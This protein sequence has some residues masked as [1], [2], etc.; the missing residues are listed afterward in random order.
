M[1]FK[2][3]QKQSKKYQLLKGK[4]QH[5]YLLKK[6]EVDVLTSHHVGK[7]GFEAIKVHAFGRLQVV[8]HTFDA[9][10]PQ[11]RVNAL[12]VSQPVRVELYVRD[13]ERELRPL[14]R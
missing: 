6:L 2:I 13:W 14:K 7:H 12:E 8:R 4:G 9:R 5:I 10:V 3:Y 11:L 1:F